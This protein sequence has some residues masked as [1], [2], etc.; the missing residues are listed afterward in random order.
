MGEEVGDWADKFIKD[1]NNAFYESVPQRATAHSGEYQFTM[2]SAAYKRGF[3]SVYFT[4]SH[5][6]PWSFARAPVATLEMDV[7]KVGDDFTRYRDT[8]FSAYKKLPASTNFDKCKCWTE[9]IMHPSGM[10]ER[11][12]FQMHQ[13]YRLLGLLNELKDREGISLV[14]LSEWKHAASNFSAPRGNSR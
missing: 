11:M 13:P 4:P 14:P 1:R 12:H 9:T 10:R 3:R 5:A 6:L 7:L 2:E 8:L